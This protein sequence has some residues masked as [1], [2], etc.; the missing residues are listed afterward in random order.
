VFVAV[1]GAVAPPSLQAEPLMP[2]RSMVVVPL[3]RSMA[4]PVL[5]KPAKVVASAA[6]DPPP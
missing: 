5:P 4:R 6:C 2:T 3:R 1:P